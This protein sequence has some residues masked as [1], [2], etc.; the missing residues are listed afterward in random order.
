[1]AAERPEGA[2]A[3]PEQD[4]EPAAPPEPAYGLDDLVAHEKGQLKLVLVVFV[5]ALLYA[6]VQR[7]RGEAPWPGGERDEPPAPT[8]PAPPDER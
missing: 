5:I 6:V 8:Q 1:M 7:L 2:P 3:T 4:P